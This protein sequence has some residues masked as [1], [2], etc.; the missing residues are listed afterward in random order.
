MLLEGIRALPENDAPLLA[1]L[2]RK[3][4]LL[5]PLA[6]FRSGYARGSD[7]AF[8]RG[9]LS[10][11][12]RRMEYVIPRGSMG[13]E[14]LHR[15]SAVHILDRLPEDDIR[16]LADETVAATPRYSGLVRAYLGRGPASRLGASASNLLRDTLKVTGAPAAGIPA[17]AAGIF[18][19]NPA[20]PMKGGTG[21]TMRVCLNAGLPVFTQQAWLPEALL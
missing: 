14:R 21:H 20:D 7:T 18:Y 4:A 13:A 5:L 1:A 17:A 12:P 6:T 2:A 16:R 3:L 10:V 15:H 11:D 9:V 19:A 8:A